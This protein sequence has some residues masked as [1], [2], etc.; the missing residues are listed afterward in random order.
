MFV[1]SDYSRQPETSKSA[2]FG[3]LP[4]VT[5]EVV[6]SAVLLAKAE[7]K[8]VLIEARGLVQKAMGA[9][10]WVVFAGFMLHASVLLLVL[11]P[12]VSQPLPEAAKW[13]LIGAPFVLALFVAWFALRSLREVQKYER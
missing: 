10:A 11:G 6:E 13:A 3:Q 1:Q 2:E 12:L 8:L 4:S 7:A 9:L 5:A